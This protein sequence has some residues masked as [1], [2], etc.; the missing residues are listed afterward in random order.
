MMFLQKFVGFE[1]LGVYARVR[2]TG[3]VGGGRSR[4]MWTK[5]WSVMTVFMRFPLVCLADP[6]GGL[7]H[8]CFKLCCGGNQC[9][10]RHLWYQYRVR[11]T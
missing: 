6:P 4:W 11:H 7:Q 1:G 9:H 3:T 5:S 8:I 2:L 10:E